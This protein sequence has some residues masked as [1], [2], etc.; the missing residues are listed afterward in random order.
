MPIFVRDGGQWRT[1]TDPQVYNGGQWRQVQN[2]HVRDGGVW[3][4]VYTRTVDPGPTPPPPPP[5]PES[6]VAT[7][8]AE[9]KQVYWQSGNQDNQSSTS[10]LFIQG[11]FDGTD[12]SQRRTLVFFNDAAIRNALSGA[13]INEIYFGV[14]REGGTHGSPTATIRLGATNAASAIPSWT[15]TGLI[16]GVSGS[17]SVARGASVEVPMT[18]ATGAAFRDGVAR[19][20]AVTTTSRSLSEYGRYFLQGAFIRFHG[21]R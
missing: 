8:D 19:S 17:A 20:I 2:A 13:T 11:T 9:S 21:T 6:F 18:N 7:F 10:P 5:Q 14:T 15:G 12:T 16:S 1:V 3:K 4:Q